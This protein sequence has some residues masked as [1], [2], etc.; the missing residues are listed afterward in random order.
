MFLID[1]VAFRL[2]IVD[3]IFVLIILPMVVMKLAIVGIGSI[4]VNEIRWLAVTTC[5]FFTEASVV[6]LVAKRD[7]SLYIAPKGNDRIGLP[8]DVASVSERGSGVA[9]MAW[10][11]SLLAMSFPPAYFV[12]VI[13]GLVVVAFAML[14]RVVRI[15]ISLSLWLVPFW[16]LHLS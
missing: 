11:R 4:V 9:E 5:F 15:G 16:F 12:G 10:A 7:T 1:V 13:V 8:A 3:N 6:A 2:G 14:V